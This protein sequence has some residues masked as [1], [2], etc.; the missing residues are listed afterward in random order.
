MVGK[1]R[2]NYVCHKCGNKTYEVDEIRTVGGFWS[3]IFDVQNKKFS[4]VS[5]KRCHYTELYKASS[6]TLGNIFDFFTG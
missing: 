6:S 2:L 3:K 5:C 1:M 4:I